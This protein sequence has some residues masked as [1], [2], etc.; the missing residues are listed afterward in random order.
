MRLA[1]LADASLVHTVRW[2]NWFIPFLDLSLRVIRL[3][4]SAHFKQ[5]LRL[6]AILLRLNLMA[7]KLQIRY[8]LK[9]IN[10]Q[11]RRTRKQSAGLNQVR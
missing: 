6:M 3:F 1:F 9:R 7:F 11:F 5:K 10:L 4:K 2:V 8:E